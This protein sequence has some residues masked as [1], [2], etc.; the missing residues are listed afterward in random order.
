M[1]LIIWLLLVVHQAVADMEA[2]VA[3][4]VFF[5]EQHHPQLRGLL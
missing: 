3:V 5:R 4:A 2:V 1:L